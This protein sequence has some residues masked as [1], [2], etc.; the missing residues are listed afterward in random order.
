MH[1]IYSS[2]QNVVE[3]RTT[4]AKARYGQTKVVDEVPKVK[5]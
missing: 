4:R 2:L 5:V 1:D 3:P